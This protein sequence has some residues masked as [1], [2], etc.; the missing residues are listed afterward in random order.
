MKR[1]N[2]Y[3]LRVGDIILTTTT[4]AVSKTIRVA[5]RSDISHAMV[6]VQ[7]GSVIDATAE[8][9]HARNI[10]RLFFEESCSIYAL[11]LRSELSDEQ[12]STICTFLRGRIGTEYSTEE[13]IQ[14]VFGGAEEWSR[15]QFCSRLVAQAFASAGVSLVNNPNFCSPADI[16]NSTELISVDNATVVVTDEEVTLWDSRV[17]T[18]Q[19]MRQATN[20]VLDG[21]RSKDVSIQTF[22]DLHRRLA[23]HPNEDEYFCG[24]L[25]ESGYL[26]LWQIEVEEN[27]WHFDFTQMSEVPE[28]IVR[29]YCENVLAVDP[30]E[31]RFAINRDAYE[32]FWQEYELLFFKKMANLY[33]NLVALRLKQVEVAKSWLEANQQG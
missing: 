10:Q 17:D 11:R 27:P 5:T 12:L 16:K 33:E 1:L 31:N 20:K 23:A 30:A 28:E 6:Y 8:G 2:E 7:A 13:A 21:A 9:V 22:D 15:K 14:T 18:P 4:A 19:M 3:S 26:T 29:P 25:E 24:L 32:K